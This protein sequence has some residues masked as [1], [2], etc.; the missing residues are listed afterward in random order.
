ME[1]EVGEVKGEKNSSAVDKEPTKDLYSVLEDI[2]KNSKEDS[3]DRLI[4]TIWTWLKDEKRVTGTGTDLVEKVN[5]EMDRENNKWSSLKRGESVAANATI[6]DLRKEL[7]QDI[8]WK[9]P[10]IKK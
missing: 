2:R 3:R 7:Q 10:A 6:H 4:K 8:S 5:K 1:V 9:F